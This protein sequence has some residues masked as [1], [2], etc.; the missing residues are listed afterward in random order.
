MTVAEFEAQVVAVAV[1]SSV[2]GIPV[3]R[4]VLPVSIN[5]RV[6]LTFGGFIDIFYNEQSGTTAYALIQHSQRVFGA[7]NTGGWHV[8]P[9]NDP[10]RHDPLADPMSFADFVVAIEQHYAAPP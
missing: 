6:P 9:F 3:V 4:R 7:D 2:C 10:T 5:L 8:H 1:G